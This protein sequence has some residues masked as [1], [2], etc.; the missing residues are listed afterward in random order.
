MASCGRGAPGPPQAPE[1]LGTTVAAL[2]QVEGQTAGQTVGHGQ[3]GIAGIRLAQIEAFV[4][5]FRVRRPQQLQRRYLA[6]LAQAQQQ[7]QIGALAAETFLGAGAH[8]GPP[9]LQVQGPLLFRQGQ[10]Q[11]IGQQ[12][13]GLQTDG[14]AGRQPGVHAGL[15][16]HGHGMILAAH[17]TEG[18]MEAVEIRGELFLQ[19]ERN[20][21]QHPLAI[22]TGHPRLGQ[23]QFRGRHQQYHP[24]TA[25]PTGCLLQAAGTDTLRGGAA[26]I[27]G[28]PAHGAQVRIGSL[29]QQGITHHAIRPENRV[30]S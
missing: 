29:Y 9:A 11:D 20:S 26:G 15:G 7:R 13:I 3:Q 25:G 12:G 19:R 21:L 16:H 8:G 1:L 2:Q 5:Q 4:R 10:G 6:L 28:H 24:A 27:E 22:P 23:Q 18:E 17:G 14:G 30:S